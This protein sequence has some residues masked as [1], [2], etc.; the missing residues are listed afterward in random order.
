[1]DSLPTAEEI[2]SQDPNINYPRPENDMEVLNGINMNNNPQNNP[3]YFGFFGPQ[4][5]V[6][7]RFNPNANNQNP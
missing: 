6:N 5:Q 4:L 3:R 1:M 7:D 2:T